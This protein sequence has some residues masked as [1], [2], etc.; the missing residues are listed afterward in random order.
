MEFQSLL[1]IALGVACSALGWAARTMY[2]AIEDL[3]RDH[4][5]HRV[6]VARDY[7]T[8]G[9]IA[10]INAKLDELLRYMRK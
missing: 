1:N 9:D 8:N 6:E 5:A 4:N 3:R 2:T 10:G 7:A